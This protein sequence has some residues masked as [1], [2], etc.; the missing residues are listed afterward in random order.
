MA[1][2]SVS[3]S[4][5]L[6]LLCAIVLLWCGLV[7]AGSP[8]HGW[9]DEHDW[10]DER[11]G[12]GRQLDGGRRGGAPS[13][14]SLAKARSKWAS[15]SPERRAELLA[16]W[17]KLQQL[18]PEERA[19][20][21]ER[22]ER[23][24][25]M[26]ERFEGELPADARE[27]LA[28]L[29]PDER[30]QALRGLMH[31]AWRERGANLR[32]RLPDH[33]RDELEKLTPQERAERMARFHESLAARGLR[34]VLDKTGERLGLPQE[35]L[36]RLRAL[37]AADMERETRALLARLSPEDAAKLG[38]KAATPAELAALSALPAQE[39]VAA[40]LAARLERDLRAKGLPEERVQALAKLSR[41]LEPRQ[42]DWTALQ[43]VAEQDRRAAVEETR[44]RRT[45][46][47]L[48]AS[49]LLDAAE[50]ARLDALQGSEAA[51]ELRKTLEALGL[52]SHRGWRGR[53]REDRGPGDRGPGE[54][55]QGDKRNGDRG[56]GD[57]G[58]GERGWGGGPDRERPPKDGWGRKDDARPRDER[59]QDGGGR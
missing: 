3:T 50:L 58:P 10:H 38:L 30:E 48:R 17:Q 40:F 34:L 22:A 21:V 39:L 53:G 52:P 32:E 36:E 31:A 35:E 27:R 20:L 41:A 57:K 46:E 15:L 23:L 49:G 28:G 33:W 55:W 42:E 26:R 56:P 11:G 16:A 47:A 18:P 45:L 12:E 2:L 7:A 43:G 4:R 37:P 24:R 13:P 44:R 54:R 1:R 25:T 14:E 5:R 8:R 19:K 9:H 51:N 6:A 59:P 29:P